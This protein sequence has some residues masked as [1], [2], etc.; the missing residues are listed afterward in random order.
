M[1]VLIAFGTTQFAWMLA[2]AVVI[3][4]EKRVAGSVLGS[5]GRRRGAL[6]QVDAHHRRGTC[7]RSHP[8][9]RVGGRLRN[10]VCY[11]GAPAGDR[12]QQNSA[13]EVHSGVAV[14]T[15]NPSGSARKPP[16]FRKP[17]QA[18]RRRRVST[19]AGVQLAQR[20]AIPGHPLAAQGVTL[21]PWTISSTTD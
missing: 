4:L 19:R 12:G 18:E 15:T 20:D 1:V 21:T 13:T 10:G 14:S 2:L 8:S 9:R 7:T 6:Y 11:D 5:D 3:W 17:R 16:R